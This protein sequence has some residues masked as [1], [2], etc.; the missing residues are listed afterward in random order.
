MAINVLIAFYSRNGATEALAKAIAEGAQGEGAEVRLRRAREHVGPDVINNVPGWKENMERM[1]ALYPAP[2]AD[3]VEWADVIRDV[4]QLQ[5]VEVEQDG[6]QFLLRSETK[7]TCGK[8]FQAAG[9]ALPPTVRQV[10][11]RPGSANPS[12]SATPDM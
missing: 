5:V 4:D 10:S 3:D 2:T 11:P 12:H 6:K 7:G 9:V 1:N 8:A